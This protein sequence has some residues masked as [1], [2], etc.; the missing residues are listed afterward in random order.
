MRLTTCFSLKCPRLVREHRLDF[1]WREA[2]EQG[3]EKTIGA[4]GR[5]R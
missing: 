2:R 4:R 1:V 3:V 5:N